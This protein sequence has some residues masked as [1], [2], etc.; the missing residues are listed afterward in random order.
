MVENTAE[1][2]LPRDMAV[3]VNPIHVSPHVGLYLIGGLHLI[4]H[5]TNGLYISN[6]NPSPI[7]RWPISPPNIVRPIVVH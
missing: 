4:M 7:F 1:R 3:S 2:L 6:P 5:R